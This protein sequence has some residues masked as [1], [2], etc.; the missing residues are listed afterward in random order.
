MAI[1]SDYSNAREFVG[2]CYPP[3]LFVVHV[4]DFLGKKTRLFSSNTQT[5]KDYVL[6]MS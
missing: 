1:T 2:S 3:L 6:I 4:R 5:T